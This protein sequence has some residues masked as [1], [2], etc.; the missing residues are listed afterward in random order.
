MTL[1]YYRAVTPAGE[2]LEGRMDVASADEVI[3][4]LQDAGNI[5]LEVRD[6]DGAGGAGLFGNLFRK[7]TLNEPQIVQFTQQLATLLGAGQP[8]DRAL[9]ILLDL[10]ESEKARNLLERVRDVVRGGSTLSDAL[11]AERETFSRL[12][13]NMVR[14]G[15]AGGSL[16]DTLRRLADY[17]ERSRQLKSSVINALIYPAFLVSMVLVS[18]F[19]LLV[20]VVPQFEQMFADMDV[21]L[22]LLTRIVV[23]VGSTLQS[24]WWLMF[25]ALVVAIAWFRRKL[26]DPVS[27]LAIDERLLGMRVV[28]DVVRK[29]ETA[30]LSRTLGTLL[31]NGVPLLGALTIA[32]NVM[33]NAALAV[34]VGNASEEVKTGSG[35]GFA[36]GQSK[37]FPKLALQMVS[38]GEESGELDTMLLKVADTFDI[39][40]KN[41]L[42][43]LLAALVPVTT[44]LMT[45]VVAVI[46]LAIILP[47]LKLTSSIQ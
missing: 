19:V 4:K 11:E 20:V 15:E 36:L 42:E 1:Y 13:V 6:A 21:E 14:A 17:L 8:L 31:K 25:G 27:R 46:M 7:P 5:A 29:L 47:I 39:E 34:A 37:K 16:E 10:P 23:G 45:A 12:Y 32:R 30:R 35:L 33:N 26:A 40:V 41:T 22:P 38:V 9:Q 24:F 43:R 28:G 3:S 18:L 2:A 44:V